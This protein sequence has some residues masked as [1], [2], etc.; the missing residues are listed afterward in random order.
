MPD[1]FFGFEFL[2]IA[3]FLSQRRSRFDSDQPHYNG[4]LSGEGRR[5]EKISKTRKNAPFD[6]KDERTKTRER[7]KSERD[8]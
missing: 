3:P 2:K 4:T 7:T 8:K 6:E 5:V 1:R